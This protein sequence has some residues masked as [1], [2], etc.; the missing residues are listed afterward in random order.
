M[1]FPGSIWQISSWVL[2]ASDQVRAGFRKIRK[3][4]GKKELHGN[5][6]GELQ[7]GEGR[8]S[9]VV[10]SLCVNEEGDTDL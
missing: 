4:L 8:D 2:L 9:G 3:P 1:L 10:V 5:Q 6:G 7:W